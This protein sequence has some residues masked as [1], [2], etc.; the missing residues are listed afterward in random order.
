[1]APVEA[2]TP[3]VPDDTGASSIPVAVPRFVLANRSESTV[4]ASICGCLTDFVG[5]DG[6]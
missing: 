2:F 6:S 4:T 3:L 5:M 1:M